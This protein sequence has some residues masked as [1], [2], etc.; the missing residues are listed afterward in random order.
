MYPQRLFNA[1]T[2]G[3]Q[4]GFLSKIVVLASDITQAVGE[5]FHE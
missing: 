2:L 4:L 5:G 1:K 3:I